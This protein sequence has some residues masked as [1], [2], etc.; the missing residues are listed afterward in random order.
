MLFLAD[1]FI[2]FT[3]MMEAIRSSETS[4]LTRATWRQIPEDSILQEK[5]GYGVCQIILQGGGLPL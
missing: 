4:L 1:L 3:L 5:I 2:P